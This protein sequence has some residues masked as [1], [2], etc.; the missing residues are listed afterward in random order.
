MIRVMTLASPRESR[1]WQPESAA[2][3][4]WDTNMHTCCAFPGP[5][6]LACICQVCCRLSAGA[7]MPIFFGL[8]LVSCCNCM[9]KSTLIGTQGC[10][11]S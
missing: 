10:I 11:T 8:G 6:M 5:G 2:E 3:L 7:L 9:G 4:G 1:Q